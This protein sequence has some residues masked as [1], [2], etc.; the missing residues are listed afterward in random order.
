MTSNPVNAQQLN[1]TCIS[2]KHMCCNLLSSSNLNLLES[3]FISFVE[4]HAI[5]QV[6]FQELIKKI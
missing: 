3:F 1:Q 2:F 5:V 4:M 6:V